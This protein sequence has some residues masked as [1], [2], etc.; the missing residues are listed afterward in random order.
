[1]CTCEVPWSLKCVLSGQ[2]S[3]VA[4]VCWSLANPGGLRCLISPNPVSWVPFECLPWRSFPGI[5][6]MY[7]DLCLVGAPQLWPRMPVDCKMHVDSPPPSNFS[8]QFM[9]SSSL[10]SLAWLSPSGWSLSRKIL[11]FT[12]PFRSLPIILS[13]LLSHFFFFLK[14]ILFKCIMFFK[15]FYWSIVDLQSC[16]NFWS[17]GK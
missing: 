6:W 14:I 7:L 5:V 15:C 2:K 16:C 12:G 1:M 10:F 13:H 11:D 8:P 3:R 4:G 9:L 17:I